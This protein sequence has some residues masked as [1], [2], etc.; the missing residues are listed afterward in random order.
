MLIDELGPFLFDHLEAAAIPCAAFD[1]HQR[2]G[3]A[4]DA[5]LRLAGLT[6]D[7]AR[8]R[9]CHRIWG[10]EVRCEG[11]PV[12]RVLAGE[13]PEAFE[14]AP[15]PL[16]CTAS[17]QGPWV[18]EAS[19]LRDRAGGLIGALLMVTDVSSQRRSEAEFQLVFHE[20]ADAFAVHELIL[21]GD[22]RPSDYRFLSVNPAFE[23][24]TGL[25]AAQI[26]GRTVREVI[27]QIEPFWI[28]TYGE[29]VATGEPRF[30]DHFTQPLGRHYEV[31]A[32]RT[33]PLRFATLFVDVTERKRQEQE[34]ERLRDQLAQARRMEAIGRLAGGVAHEFN[35]MLNIILANAEMALE[36]LPLFGPHHEAVSQIRS[37]A[38]RSAAL[39]SQLLAFARKQP[40]APKMMELNAHVVTLSS[41]LRRLLGEGIQMEW[42]PSTEPAD[43]L[44]DPSQVDQILTNLCVNARDAMDGAGRITLET[45]VVDITEADCLEA[46]E[47]TPG[48][49]VMLAV[50]DTGCGMDA[51]TRAH[52]FEPFYTTKSM[53]KGT[54]LGLA[55]VH[56][57][58]SQ[59]DGFICVRSA[60]GAGTTFHVLLPLRDPGVRTPVPVA[61]PVDTLGT[62]TLLLVED[63]PEI[64][65]V[66]RRILERHGYRVLAA[67]GAG[68]ALALAAEHRAQIRLLITDVIMPVMN[69]DELARRVRALVPGIRV[70][71]MSGYTADH[72]VWHGVLEP[73]VHFIQKPFTKADFTGTIRRI[74]DM[75]GGDPASS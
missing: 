31:K 50:T 55:T 36:D 18:H 16:A 21:D 1:L 72:I 47:A 20:M 33:A 40:I 38:R 66:A 23:R 15:G 58:V 17:T 44:M 75:P 6:A 30:F 25:R 62:E 61:R 73:G 67:P 11:C 39:T 68:E 42:R 9:E 56:G 69:G 14:L 28:E 65:H 26:L 59:N 5:F 7:Q 41:L 19:P 37:A 48:R 52:L 34:R 4:N 60:P 3:W 54:G 46:A 74:L 32:F 57:I 22:G 51:E 64:L 35:N 63:E 71:F 27:P 53:D 49:Y 8:A 45:S 12:A 2:L 43:V 24:L 10:L 70:L 29:V 13:A